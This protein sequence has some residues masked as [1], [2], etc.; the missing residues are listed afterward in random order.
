MPHRR[1]RAR[2]FTIRGRPYPVLLPKLGDPRL[3]L[4]AVIISLQV[5]GQI[6]FHFELSIAQILLAIGTVRGARG[7]DRDAPA[8]RHPL[9]GE[10]DADRQ[11]RRVR[12]ARSRHGARRL[13]EPAR[14]VD[15]RRN[16]R[17]LAAL[18]ARDPLARRAHLQSVQHRPRP[19]LP[20]AR[21]DSRCAA[22]LLV[23][24]D[25]GLARA[26]ARD[27]RRRRLPDPPAAEAAAGRARLL[28]HVRASRSACSRSPGTR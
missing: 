6:G 9:A 15:L 3:H 18:E 21:P 7:R 12:P 25:V 16:R 13:V 28:D 5:I 10:R 2:R 22:R 1:L 23:G 4:A 8:A 20:P 27:H 14:L 17:G 24:P 11:R 19:L 26:R